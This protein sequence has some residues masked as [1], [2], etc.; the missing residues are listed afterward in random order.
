MTPQELWRLK[1]LAC[2]Q[3][4]ARAGEVFQRL[5]TAPAV[6]TRL[7]ER[8]RAQASALVAD[9]Q[10][11]PGSYLV[12]E[13]QRTGRT[14]L[15]VAESILLACQREDIAAPLIE[16]E[17]V[18]GKREVRAAASA[19]GVEAARVACLAALEALAPGQ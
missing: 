2:Q 13:A 14:E 11:T 1:F 9:P 6:Q 7:Y 3:I 12:A 17:R 15:Q 5:G 8:K 4:D 19:E 10:T 18:G 16:A